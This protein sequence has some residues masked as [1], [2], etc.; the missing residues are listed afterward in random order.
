L[1]NIAVILAGGSGSRLG[2]DYPKQF[3]KVAGKQLIE[4]TIEIFQAHPG[5]DDIIIVS[6]PEYTHGVLDLVNR[7]GYSKVTKVVNGGPARTDSTRAAILALDDHPADDNVLFHDAVRPFLSGSVIDRCL[8]ALES[9]SAVDVVVRSADT[10]VVIDGSGAIESIPD[11]ATIRRGQTPQAFRLGLI[12]EAYERLGDHPGFTP[13]CDCG[14]V[15]HT[16]PGERIVTVEGDA[17]NIKVTEPLDLFL[18]DKLF[19]SR[20]DIVQPEENAERTADRIKGKVLVVFGGSSGIGLGLHEMAL[21]LG[22]RSYS[23]SRGTTGTDVAIDASVAEA[24]ERVAVAEGRIDFIVNTAA[25]FMRRALMHMTSDEM[26]QCINVNLAGAFTV[27]RLGYPY[28]AATGG[29]LLLYT[30]SSYTRGRA[31]S[32][33]YSATKAGVVNMAQALADEWAPQ[34]V[35]VNC[36]NPERT[37]TPM[38]VRN[39]GYEPP[40]SLLTVQRVAEVSLAVLVSDRSGQVIDIRRPAGSDAPDFLSAVADTMTPEPLGQ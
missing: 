37:A 6:R 29:G 33:V 5:I 23:F 14:V 12:R 30:S 8:Q 32:S 35:R 7:N 1:S 36:I 15:F 40:E 10:L 17:E 34:G 13:T 19:Q 20:G 9:A 4:H 2:L 39:F 27:A 28:L 16:L 25:V 31:F 3:A 11:R 18:A 24:L 21:R 22:A 38:R 26:L